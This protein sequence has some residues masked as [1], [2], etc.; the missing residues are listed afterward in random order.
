M[1]GIGELATGVAANGVGSL[2]NRAT[3]SVR[4]RWQRAR[5]AQLQMENAT[6]SYPG[7]LAALGVASRNLE[8]I[9]D[10]VLQLNASSGAFDPQKVLVEAHT[11]RLFK[12]AMPTILRSVPQTNA[13]H[14]SYGRNQGVIA[15]ISLSIKARVGNYS[16]L[17]VLQE[18]DLRSDHVCARPPNLDLSQTDP[19][20]LIVSFVPVEGLSQLE[21]ELALLL[22]MSMSALED[23]RAALRRLTRLSPVA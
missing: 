6:T 8:T 14:I 15:G 22:D 1:F 16:E 23:C 4:T 7:L 20:H 10:H 19:A 21:Q 2:L 12:A 9:T 18:R 17:Y 11:K 3:R 5:Y 13:L